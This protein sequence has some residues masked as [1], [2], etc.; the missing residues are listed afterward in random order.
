MGK[1]A[2]AEV[3]TTAPETSAT[4]EGLSPEIASAMNSVFGAP[5][6]EAAPPGDA[7][8]A[9]D[10]SVDVEVPSGDETASKEEKPEDVKIV[11]LSRVRDRIEKQRVEAEHILA[12]AQRRVEATEAREKR[13]ADAERTL[14]EREE[15][16][17]ILDSGDPAEY[18]AR[19]KRDPREFLERLARSGQPEARDTSRLTKLEREAEDLRKELLRVQQEKQAQDKQETEAQRAA[20]HAALRREADE[21]FVA[22]ISPETHPHLTEAYTANEVPAIA[23]SVLSEIVGTDAKGNPVSRVRAYEMAYGHLPDDATIAS[24]LEEREKSR[25][26]AKAQGGGWKKKTTAADKPTVAP[27][28]A[29]I[30]PSRSI[31]TDSRPRASG[32]LPQEELDRQSIEILEAALKN[33]K[34]E[35]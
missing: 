2:T 16:I 3:T 18:F 25:Q 4:P 29:K 6:T 14:R 1:E 24:Y 5:K 33:K 9:D 22:L 23:R 27:R 32:N 34:K 17:A 35:E 21:K 19:T 28:P 11:S 15:L 12:E 13:I 31:S 20:R 26:Q 8:A 10:G 7:A 30:P